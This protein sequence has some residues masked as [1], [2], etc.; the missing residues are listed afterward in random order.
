MIPIV[1][2]ASGTGSG[3]ESIADAVQAGR[4][5]AEI[6]GVVCDQPAARVLEK[7]RNRGIK[8]ILV[9]KAQG[10]SRAA[11]DERILSEILPLQP[12]FLVMAGYMRIV[13]SKLL[14]SFRSERGY[15]RV[16]NIHPSLLP[17][18]PGVGAYA[19]AFRYGTKVA[20]ATVHL[21]ELEVDSGPICAQVAFPI[22]GLRSEAEVEEKG[23]AL[24]QK[25]YPET[26]SWVLPEKF[27][28]EL[29]ETA[30]AARR[31]C[32]RPY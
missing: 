22:D 16:V 25:L 23:K 5:D 1:I 30:K 26:L 24:E 7:A 8:T 20:G 4:L 15:A 19:Q 2:F 21:V 11:H 17:S 29:R 12:R 6:R 13:S 10:E 28:I 27:D 14:E 9:P 32:V 18:F 31:L 3:F